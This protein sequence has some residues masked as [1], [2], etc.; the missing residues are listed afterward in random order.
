MTETTSGISGLRIYDF[1]RCTGE[2]SN[3]RIVP[4]LNDFWTQALAFSDNMKYLYLA[5]IFNIYQIDLSLSEP[6]AHLETIQ[7]LSG[8]CSALFFTPAPDGKIYILPFFPG[9]LHLIGSINHPSLPSLSA[10]VD[11]FFPLPTYGADAIPHFPYYRLGEWE[12]AICDTINLQQVGDGFYKSHFVKD[13][14]VPDKDKDNFSYLSPIIGTNDPKTRQEMLKYRNMSSILEDYA[15]EKNEF[16]KNKK[17]E[18]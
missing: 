16:L 13:E 15:E 2:L 17:D 5:D 8:S 9:I 6:F 14:I 12:G 3:L 10:D 1:D 4:Y 11:P 7:N 18:N